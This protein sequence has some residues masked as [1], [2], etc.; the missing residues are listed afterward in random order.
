MNP[1]RPPIEWTPDKLKVLR[2]YYPT[3]LNHSLVMWLK[4]SERTLQRKAKS[5]GI[6]KVDNFHELRSDEI[7]NRLSDAVK[8]AYSEGRMVSQFQRGIR[9][10]PEGE[11]QPGFKFTGE[12]EEA[13]K[14]KIRRTYRKM[15]L[16]KI[17]GLKK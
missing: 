10:N 2:D 8:K 17:Y 6:Q 15:K 12:I 11:F 7:S 3:M 5:L 4:C 9:N 14:D 13:R 16:L 1:N